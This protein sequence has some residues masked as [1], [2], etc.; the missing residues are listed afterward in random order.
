MPLRPLASEGCGVCMLASETRGSRQLGGEARD[1]KGITMHLFA[2]RSTWQ[3][4][5]GGATLSSATSPIVRAALA[6]AAN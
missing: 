2:R 6:A 4:V 3:E 1:V 5:R